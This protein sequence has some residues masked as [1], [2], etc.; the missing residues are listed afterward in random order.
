MKIIVVGCGKIGK[1]IIDSLIEEKHNIVA[2]DHNP[3]VVETITNTFDVMAV[4]GM[5]T[6]IEILNQAGVG[7]A[8]LFVGVQP[9]R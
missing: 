8:D 2:I 7:Q 3:K 9:W 1:T 6:S 4:C 5:A